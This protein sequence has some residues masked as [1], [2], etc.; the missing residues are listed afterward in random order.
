MASLLYEREH[1]R[2]SA[3]EQTC[4][5]APDVRSKENL[6]APLAPTNSVLTAVQLADMYRLG[7]IFVTYA[8]L[9]LGLK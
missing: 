7:N 9:D 3:E 4:T 8:R 6:W 2:L 5:A 1:R